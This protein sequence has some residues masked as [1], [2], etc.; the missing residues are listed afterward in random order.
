VCE[1]V[2]D[3]ADLVVALAEMSKQRPQ[4]LLLYPLPIAPTDIQRISEFGLTQK[5]LTAA[6]VRE[7]AEQGILMF[8]GPQL[9]EQYRLAG[10]YIDKI[11]RG[12]RPADLPIQEPTKFELVINMKTAKALGLPIPRSLLLRADRVIE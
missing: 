5:L 10:V 8:Y 4:A 7:Y 12:A 9:A 3:A 1:T 11:L 6:I 2:R